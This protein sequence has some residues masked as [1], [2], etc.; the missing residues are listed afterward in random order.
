MK[1]N[2]EMFRAYDLR[3]VVDRDLN[4]EIVECLGKAH[5]TYLKRNG[6]TKAIV[7]R[8]SRATSPEYS[9][10]IIRGLSWAGVFRGNEGV[11]ILVRPAWEAPDPF[12]PRASNEARIKPDWNSQSTLPRRR[13]QACAASNPES[14]KKDSRTAPGAICKPLWSARTENRGISH[15]SRASSSRAKTGQ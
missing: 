14:S 15:R 13:E 7:A 5:G 1:I 10:A 2:P 3:G 11:M 4:P 8:D 9:Q 6:I 12:V